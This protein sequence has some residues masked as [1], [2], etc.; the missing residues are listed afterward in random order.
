MMLREQRVRSTKLAEEEIL[1]ESTRGVD[2][3]GVY[4]NERAVS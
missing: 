2:Q 4:K 3:E 1:P